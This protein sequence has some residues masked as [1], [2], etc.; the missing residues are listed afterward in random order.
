MVAIVDDREDV[1]GRCP[2]LVHVK[3]YIFFAGTADINAPPPPPTPTTPSPTTPGG[4]HFFRPKFP[5]QHVPFKTRLLSKGA[6]EKELPRINQPQVEVKKKSDTNFN[7]PQHPDPTALVKDENAGLKV[8]ERSS[9]VHVGSKNDSHATRAGGE[10]NR[11]EE[12]GRGV[13]EEGEEGQGGGEKGGGQEEGKDREV[14][15]R[16]EEEGDRKNKVGEKEGEERGKEGGGEGG[17]GTREA[18]RGQGERREGGR[19]ER[20]REEKEG[21]EG[22]EKQSGK[23]MV[24]DKANDSSSSSSSS[25]SD[26][27]DSSSSS[28]SEI[29]DSL[30]EH[31]GEEEQDEKGKEEQIIHLEMVATKP[32]TG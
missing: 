23:K 7:M 22:G 32:N 30:F 18:E 1:W 17:E 4:P 3:P 9:S 11:N 12:G 25:D 13:G 6:N 20:A 2:N 8:S 27:E 15:E 24:K 26:S 19:E 14:K 28:S 29:D 16:G 21:R 31:L 5:P 10:G